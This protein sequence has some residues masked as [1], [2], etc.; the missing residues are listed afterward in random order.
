M[1]AGPETT[2]ELIVALDRPTLAGA[3]EIVDALDARCHFYKIGLELFTS[4]G[5]AAV[6]A[7]RAR[8]ADIFLDLKLHDIPNTV[9]GAAR[10][11]AAL[12]VRLLTV[13]ATGGG[14]M[15]AAAVEGAGEG[16]ERGGT[17]C[18]VLAVTVLTSLD[19]AVVGE[20]WGR[21]DVQVDGEV[22]RLARLSAVAGAHGVVCS[23][24]EVAGVRAA[25][26]SLAPLVPGLRMP[27]DPSDDQSRVVTPAAAARDG[28]RY[29]VLGRAVTAA[30]G[31]RCGV[32]RH[33]RLAR[34]VGR[35]GT[36]YGD[37]RCRPL[38]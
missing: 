17:P 25:S 37:S 14:P 3:L 29:F 26:P 36:V 33:S 38:A 2:P 34:T 20:A 5:P 15:I 16:S 4:A 23:G 12:G 7:L 31:C 8:G 11:A 10:T 1:T 13:H 21:T 24:A 27:G 19:A 6:E 30:R 32:G 18:G 35:D 9:R 28:A 22:L